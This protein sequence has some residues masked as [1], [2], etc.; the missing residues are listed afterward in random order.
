MKPFKLRLLQSYFSLCL[1]SLSAHADQQTLTIA[2]WGG[3]YERAQQKALFGP[4]EAATG[5]Q[6]NTQYL[7]W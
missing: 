4:F 3:S 7:Q 5:I 6:I 1:G 2:T